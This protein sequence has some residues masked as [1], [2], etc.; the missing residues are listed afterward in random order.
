MKRFASK[1]AAVAAYLLLVVMGI[2]GFMRIESVR[3]E[4]ATIIAE[5][6]QQRE[7]ERAALT[8]QLCE[9]SKISREGLRQQ[10]LATAK[11]ARTLV[12]AQ[13]P[14][15][16]QNVVEFQDEQLSLLPQIKCDSNGN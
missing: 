12:P 11:L 5:Q 1:Y 2:V 9:Q 3:K 10:I 16:V 13:S 4:R 8:N 15:L 6:T 14:E 7:V